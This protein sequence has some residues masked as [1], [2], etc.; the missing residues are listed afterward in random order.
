[1]NN[2]KQDEEL[3]YTFGQVEP[4]PEP[5]LQEP[6]QPGGGNEDPAA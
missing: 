4:E 1:M 6:E 2:F 3:L 5:E